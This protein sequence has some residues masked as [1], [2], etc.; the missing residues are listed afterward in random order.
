MKCPVCGAEFKFRKGKIYCSV[1][2]KEKA[3]YYR[4][5]NGVFRHKPGYESLRFAILKQAKRDGALDRFVRTESF[6]QLFPELTPEQIKMKGE[7]R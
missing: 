4:N 3:K 7:T 2:C 6:Y 1:R 5:S